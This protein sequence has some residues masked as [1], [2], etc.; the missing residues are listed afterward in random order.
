[1]LIQ[2]KCCPIC[3][4]ENSRNLISIPYEEMKELLSNY[5]NFNELVFND[6]K[7]LEYS[8]MECS[9]CKSLYQEYMPS[10]LFSEI[11]YEKWIDPN[12]SFE[13]QTTKYSLGFYSRMQYEI[14]LILNIFN[15]THP[16]DIKVL[17]FGAGWGEWSILA[18]A[19][20]IDVYAA[21]L[22]K[23]RITHLKK[24]N[25]KII[26]LEEASKHKFDYIRSDQVFEH[27]GEPADILQ[28]LSDILADD[29]IIRLAVPDTK[30]FFEKFEPSKI[31]KDSDFKSFYN[32]IFPLEHLNCFTPK[33]LEILGN[34][35]K[36][37]RYKSSTNWKIGN[38]V[39]NL[40]KPVVNKYLKDKNNICFKKMQ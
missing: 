39:S 13:Y 3:N 4:D 23:S 24:N 25:I 32:P 34:M 38:I 20:G 40:Y 2:R 30:N 36:L 11:L 1:M 26:S 6:F 29:G 10:D 5:N 27:L 31:K 33:N 15:N 35:C 9:N 21:E 16:S 18:K 28:K 22:S 37:Q 17:D 8:L 7:N 12:K 19:H 14:N